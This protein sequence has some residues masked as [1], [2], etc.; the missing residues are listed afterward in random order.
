[1]DDAKEE[2]GSKV[3][4][5][6]KA[7]LI[8]KRIDVLRPKLLDLTRRN[9]LISTKF[10]ERSNSLIRIVDEVPELILE[11]IIS[12]EMRN[13]PL[14]DLKVD[15]KDEHTREFQSSL[16]EARLNDEIYSTRLDKI[17]QDSDESP[18]LLAQAER[19]LKDRLRERLNMPLRQTK[20][21]LSL[22]K[23]AENHGIS[24]HYELPQGDQQ[25]EDGRHTDED[26]QTLMFWKDD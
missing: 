23:H 14:P 19:Q 24:P 15:P 12:D 13:V 22:Q 21:N 3:R 25:H 1:M 18:N 5:E 2:I 10:S 6:E 20:S 16:A 9:P 8:Q 11:S 17:D 7:K 4:N 26:I